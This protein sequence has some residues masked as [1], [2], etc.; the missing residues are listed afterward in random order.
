MRPA[1]ASGEFPFL[2]S[3]PDDSDMAVS[4]DINAT[5]GAILLG[6]L[7]AALFVARLL[8]VPFTDFVCKVERNGD[9]A[10]RRL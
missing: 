5:Y 1:R 6:S 10:G 3:F 2:P 8:F 9:S 7:F 4:G